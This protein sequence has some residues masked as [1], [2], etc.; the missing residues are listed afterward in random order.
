[1]AGGALAALAYEL[2]AVRHATPGQLWSGLVLEGCGIGL[3][4]AGIA[5]VVVESVPADRTGVSSGI[6]T[7]CRTVGGAIG[8]T[9]CGALLAASTATSGTGHPGPHAYTLAFAGFGLALAL[10]S[11]VATRIPRI[12]SSSTA[13]CRSCGTGTCSPTSTPAAPCATTTA[14][15]APR[16]GPTRP[17]PDSYGGRLVAMAGER[18][19]PPRWVEISAVCTDP[20]HRGQGLA[21]RLVRAVAH[22]IRARGEQSFPHAAATNS[23][24]IRLYL[25]IGFTLRRETTFTAV[26]SPA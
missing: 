9:V 15:P 24:A 21:S 14:S 17:I 26:R 25:A 8:T 22:G 12:L 6:N 5:A 13:C 4:F 2:L 20:A 19:H 3:A 23:G 10:S 18:L 11:L 7:I 16:R 1:M